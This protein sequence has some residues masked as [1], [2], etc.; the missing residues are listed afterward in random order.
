MRKSA[1]RK[2]VALGVASMIHSAGAHY[3]GILG[4][5]Q[6]AARTT[7]R[8]AAIDKARAQWLN[9]LMVDETRAWMSLGEADRG[10]LSGLVAVLV[11]AGMAHTR[12]AGTVDTLELRIIRGAIS[13]ADQCGRAG[14]VIDEPTARAFQ[15]ACFHAIISACSREAI[16]A[17]AH[18]L[19]EAAAAMPPDTSAGDALL[20][21]QHLAQPV[22]AGF[23]AT[24]APA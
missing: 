2:P 21:H 11:L 14:S 20:A 1:K 16:A 7:T 12:D 17:A 23:A 19:Q 8:N 13:A 22:A 10:C 3:A 15:T 18:G 5:R 6:Q 4:Q 24:S 9:A